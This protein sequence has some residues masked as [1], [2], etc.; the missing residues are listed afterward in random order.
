MDPLKTKTTKTKNKKRERREEREGQREKDRERER[1]DAGVDTEHS[2]FTHLD[3]TGLLQGYMTYRRQSIITKILNTQR[4]YM[5]VVLELSLPSQF[6]VRIQ[7][8]KAK[9]TKCRH[10]H[11]RDSKS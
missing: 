2:R 7:P 5:T 3:R 8:R 10:Y 4:G 11:K 6:G 1:E 9:S